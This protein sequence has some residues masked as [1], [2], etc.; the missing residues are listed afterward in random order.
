MAP[1]PIFGMNVVGRTIRYP[2]MGACCIPNVW[3]SARKSYD[4]TLGGTRRA[5]GLRRASGQRRLR[6]RDKRELYFQLTSTFDFA[7]SLP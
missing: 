6:R 5:A 3:Y 1:N 7:L 4:G 2:V